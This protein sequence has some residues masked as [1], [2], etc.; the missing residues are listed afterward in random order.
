MQRIAQSLGCP[1]LAF[2]ADGLAGPD[3]LEGMMRWRMR[4]AAG[5]LVLM[6]A[7]CVPV[8]TS[9]GQAPSPPYQQSEPRDTGG[10]H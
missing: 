10:M 7:G 9:P 2:V 1:S 8:P 3:A 6:L 5:F 4:L